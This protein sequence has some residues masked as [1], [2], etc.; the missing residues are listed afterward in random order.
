MLARVQRAW[1]P[2]AQC[3]NQTSPVDL[4][5]MDLTV[6][7]DLVIGSFSSASKAA[8]LFVM[9]FALRVSRMPVCKKGIDLF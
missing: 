1:L 8:P 3:R 9:S 2:A 5:L 6:L 4:S 7:R